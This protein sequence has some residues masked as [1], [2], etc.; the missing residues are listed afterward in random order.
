VLA[1]WCTD[2][3]LSVSVVVVYSQSVIIVGPPHCPGS[4]LLS[5]APVGNGPAA[6]S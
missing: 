4:A 1:D 3:L 2:D 5:I 6:T